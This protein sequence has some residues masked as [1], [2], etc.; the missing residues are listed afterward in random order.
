MR[1][2]LVG[3]RLREDAANALVRSRCAGGVHMLGIQ[4][5]ASRSSGSEGRPRAGCKMGKPQMILSIARN[6]ARR[7]GGDVRNVGGSRAG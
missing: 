3:L 7:G 2:A 4:D 1:G 5:T 6:R